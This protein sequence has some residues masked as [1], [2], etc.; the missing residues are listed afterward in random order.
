MID[1][2][3]SFETYPT[4][5]SWNQEYG[6]SYDVKIRN[7]D[8]TKEEKDK[9]Y[10][11]LDTEGFYDGLNMIIDDWEESEKVLSFGT[12][13][14]KNQISVNIENLS[15]KQ[16]K[17]KRKSW[18]K[19]GYTYDRHGT[20]IMTMFKKVEKPIFSVGF[21]GRQSG[22]LVLYKWNGYNYSGSGWNYSKEELNEMNKEEVSFV[23]KVL[24]EFEKLH[25]NLL[26]EVKY[27]INNYEVKD[28][29]CQVIET[30]KILVEK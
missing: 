29:E 15:E 23:Y 8:L 11:M 4:M 28:E 24:K 20:K 16:I 19:N 18:E 9:V 21:N 12:F 1:F 22:H 14:D 27:L 30:K 26:E 7:L 13:N 17:E 25:N 10:D 5:N 6:Y 2:I 3:T